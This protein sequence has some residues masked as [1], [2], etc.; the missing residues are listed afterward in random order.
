MPPDRID[1]T[2]EQLAELRARLGLAEH[3][4]DP[5]P[6]DL[7]VCLQARAIVQAAERAWLDGEGPP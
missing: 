7:I 2:A 6:D 5:G 3:D 4:P 1:F